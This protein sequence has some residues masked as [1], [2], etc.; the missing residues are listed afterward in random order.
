M[1]MT[2]LIDP[3]H[4]RLY[5]CRTLAGVLAQLHA[6]RKHSVTMSERGLDGEPYAYATCDRGGLWVVTHQHLGDVGFHAGDR[7]CVVKV[8]S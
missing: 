3:K 7:V 6:T 1:T 5:Q 8:S 4:K 2:K